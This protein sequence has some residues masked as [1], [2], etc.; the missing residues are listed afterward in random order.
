MIEAFDPGNGELVG[1]GIGVYRPALFRGCQP[2]IFALAP[3]LREAITAGRVTGQLY[4]GRW[5]DI[6]SP[7]RLRAVNA[8]LGYELDGEDW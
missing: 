3:I 5:L 1:T 2:G 4:R 8:A 6:G 7:E